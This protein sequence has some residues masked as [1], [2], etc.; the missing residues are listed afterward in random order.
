MLVYSRLR[1]PPR[2]LPRHV[3]PH[4][5]TVSPTGR[6]YFIREVGDGF[7]D[8]ALALPFPTTFPPY[9][10][11]IILVTVLLRAALLPVAVWVRAR[12]IGELL[13]VLNAS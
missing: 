12:T 7:L 2:N 13:L 9:S 1:H 5:R 11:T 4:Y 3:A 8:L 10:S 6:R